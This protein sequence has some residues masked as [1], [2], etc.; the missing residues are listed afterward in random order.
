MPVNVSFKTLTQSTF[1]LELDEN[2]SVA[3][4]K[5]KIAERGD[6]F[7]VDLQKLIYNGKILDDSQK[8]SDIGFESTKFVVVMLTRRKVPVPEPTAEVPKEV[9]ATTQAA[10]APAP[11]Q[12]PTTQQPA[13]AA[14]QAPAEN[15][16]A[17]Q[18]QSIEAI[19]GM[20]YP[21]DQV[22]AA[23]RAAYWNAD[24]AVEFLLT[25]IPEVA[26][27][28]AA[29]LPQDDGDDDDLLEGPGDLAALANIPHL[30]EI[31]A[32]VQRN[33]EMLGS[34]LQQLAAVN[35]DLVQAIQGNQQGFIDIL[36]AAPTDGGAAGG[37]AP[38]GGGQRARNE[39][40][41]HLSAEELAA[42]NRIKSM[43]F[44]VSEQVI[45]EAYFAC[46]KNEEAAINFI[47][48]NME[49]P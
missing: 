5:A 23:L 25:G 6:E 26:A 22:Q 18:E 2:Q 3:E 29:V 46:D 19:A 13:A 27:D 39:H 36:N 40:V 12:I 47:L 24:R 45:V 31:R 32:M 33:P 21:R 1:N 8:V 43:G 48:S 44:Q 20:G 42:I 7:A 35:P 49:E 11:V 4:V 41:I 16:T 38:Q 17:E 9:P 14:Q 34:I 15:L 30:D 10:P 37:N 28:E